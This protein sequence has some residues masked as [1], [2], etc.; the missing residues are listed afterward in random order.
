MLQLLQGVVAEGTAKAAKS[1]ARPV[2]G[3]TGTTNDFTDAWFVGFSPSLTV[4]VWVG[5]DAKVTLGNKE[6]GAVVALPIWIDY[7]QE[8]LKDKPVE[9]FAAVETSEEG[10]SEA[11]EI[12]TY[13]DQK[14]LFV[15]D[16]PATSPAKKP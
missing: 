6:A 13:S 10:P 16:L 4:A 1:L 9:T 5:F 3:K 11:P 8:I 15:E 2:G 12:T 7:M 14:K